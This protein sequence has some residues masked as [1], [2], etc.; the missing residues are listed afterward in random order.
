MADPDH[1]RKHR[2]RSV[3]EQG[4]SIGTITCYA[5]EKKWD[6]EMSM[7]WRVIAFC[8]FVK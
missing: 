1:G 3:I 5:Q 7:D 2:N 6:R 4:E 8:I